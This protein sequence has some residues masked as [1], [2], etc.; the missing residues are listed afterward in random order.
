MELKIIF[1]EMSWASYKFELLLFFNYYYYYLLLFCLISLFGLTL[2]GT[3]YE[4]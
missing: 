2:C 3:E 1:Y 4:S